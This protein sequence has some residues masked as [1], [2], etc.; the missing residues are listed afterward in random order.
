MSGLALEAS[1]V[2]RQ[3]A[4]ADQPPRTPRQSLWCAGARIGSVEP[5]FFARLAP[6]P[7]LVKG[8]MRGDESGWELQ[9]D[10]TGSLSRLAHLMRD[11]GLAHVWRDE[12]LAVTDEAGCA[13]G[14][15]ERAVVRPLGITTF[16]V[17][18]AAL[19]PDGRHWVQQRSLAK[20]NDPGLWDTLMGGMVPA[21]ESL[22]TALARETREEA[23]LD[24][25]QLQGLRWRGRIPTRRPSGDIEG[26]YVIEHIDWFDCVLPWGVTPCNQ[27][28]EVEQFVLLDAGQLADKLLGE[29]FT[30]EAALVL[31]HHVP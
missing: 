23:G 5:D 3:R 20:A 4:R 27:D 19:S 31:T 10:V 7:G 9:G 18:L 17:H 13:V 11:A 8:T 1:W 28:G 21:G 22:E 14:T 24:L 29:Q 30:L 16:A 25:S 2:A 15:V 26:G 12:Q 6:P